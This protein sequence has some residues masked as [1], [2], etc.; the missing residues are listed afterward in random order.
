MLAES[1]KLTH[2][3]RVSLSIPSIKISTFET[4]IAYHRDFERP[5]TYG[6]SGTDRM[7]QILVPTG[8]VHA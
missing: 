5:P 6:G 1:K 3:V 2:W 7:L 8:T 4:L